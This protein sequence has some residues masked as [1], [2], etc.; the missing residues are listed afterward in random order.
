MTI[1]DNEAVFNAWL[2][3]DQEVSG[4][5][6]PITTEA[7]HTRALSLIEPLMTRVSQ[8]AAHPLSALL[9]LLIHRIAA[10]EAL[11]FPLPE[12]SM[13]RRLGFLMEQHD[14]TVPRVAQATGLPEV[15]LEALLAG[16]GEGDLTVDQLRALAEHLHLQPRNLL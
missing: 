9:G 6:R 14:L 7:N 10:Y 1:P 16:V 15:Q 11:T 4:L 2:R 3:L 8:D 13:S 5:L 12:V